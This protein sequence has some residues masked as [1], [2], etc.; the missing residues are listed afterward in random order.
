MATTTYSG[1]VYG[2]GV[3]GVSSYG[4]SSV[5]YVPDG[6]SVTATSDSGVIVIGDATSVVVG[7]VAASIFS[8]V[9]VVVAGQGIVVPNG[10]S[11]SFYVGD[12]T[13]RSVN[14]INVFGIDVIAFVGDT[15]IA[16]GATTGTTSVSSSFS[17]NDA[18]VVFGKAVVELVGIS[19][20]AVTGD[21]FVSASA[22]T[23]LVGVTSTFF[24]G[25]LT[26]ATTSF[27]YVA[28]NY[29]KSLT[30]YVDGYPSRVVYVDA[31]PS[32]VVYVEPKADQYN[33]TASVAET[34]S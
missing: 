9:G 16:A 19:D 8:S 1:A 24:N 17:I 13:T 28:A 32:R 3:Y 12:V 29:D 26:V 27:S 31:Y 34:W 10:V 20:A 15:T 4:V 25:L 18:V 22:N 11:S 2:V 14:F 5:S 23:V 6:I 7:V 30:V 33:R 21:I